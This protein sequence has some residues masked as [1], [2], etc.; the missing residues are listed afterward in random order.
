MDGLVFAGLLAGAVA[1]GLV[2]WIAAQARLGKAAQLAASDAAR[3]RSE[4]DGAR[5]ERERAEAAL[6]DARGRL[7]TEQQTRAA[8]EARVA[9]A[10]KKIAEL[11]QFIDETKGQMES[12]YAKLSRDALSS[13]IQ[14]LN[15]LVKPQLDGTK[16]GIEK[17]LEGKSASIEN[18]LKPIREMLETY[19]NELKQTEQQ[20]AQ[21]FGGIEEQIRNLLTAHERAQ[22]ET[23]KLVNALKVPTVSGSW[24]ENSLRNTVELSGMSEFCDFL[25]QETVE[26]DDGRRLRPDMI[27]RLPNERVIAVD[28]KAPLE[29]YIEA[30]GEPDDEKKRALLSQHAR[31][32]K[33]HV[34]LLSKKEYQASVGETLDFTVLFLGG[35]HFLSSALLVDPAIFE[36]AVHRKIYLATPTI[37]LPLLRAVSAGWKAER[38]EENA[39]RALE[40]GKE[41]Y[42]RFVRVFEYL[43]PVGDSL[44]K[45]MEKYNAAVKSINTRL[46]P[47]VEKLQEFAGGMKDAPQLKQIEKAVESLNKDDSRLD[48][49]QGKLFDRN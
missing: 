35:E 22:H 32:L 37:L 29:A 8:A 30:A 15:E 9:E 36:Y 49:P 13:A 40:I 10:E 20:R 1:G 25:V 46:I 3:A 18:L 28:S 5:A 17:T 42:L 26:T 12:T 7:E 48:L 38:A 19:R 24:G 23:S 16:T 34:D 4:R 14:Q 27:I 44:S 11:K 39:L 21:A 41:L 33:R 45:A 47:H 6:R 43:E 2:G 31:N